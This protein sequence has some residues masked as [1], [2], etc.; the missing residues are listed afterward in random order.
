M[1]RM[2]KGLAVILSLL[3]SLSGAVQVFA[4]TDN[5]IKLRTEEDFLLFAK[6]SYTQMFSEGKKFSLQNDLDLSGMEIEP[7]P[8]FCGTFEGNGHEIRGITIERSG[9]DVGLFRYVE[10]GAVISDLHLSGTITSGADSEHVGGIAGVNRGQISG[11]SFRGMVTGESEVGGIAGYNDETGQ[12]ENCQN[13]GTITGTRRTGGIAGYQEGLIESCVNQGFVNTE[14]ENIVESDESRESQ[15]LDREKLRDNFREEKVQDAGGIAGY[16]EGVIIHCENKASVGYERMGDY[17]G[18]IA[19]RQNGQIQFCE[20]SGNVTGRRYVGGIAGQLEPYLHFLYEPDT[21][22][23][24][25]QKMDELGEIRDTISEILDDTTDQT[26]E[27]LDESDRLMKEIR[28]ITKDYKQEQ[29]EKRD[30]FRE[31]SE[32]HLDAIQ[33]TLD[34]LELDIGSRDARNAMSRISKNAARSKALLNELGNVKPEKGTPSDWEEQELYSQPGQDFW[35]ED[36]DWNQNA[37]AIKEAAA[38]EILYHYGIVREIASCI[39]EILDDIEIVIFNGS[40]DIEDD[41]QDFMDDMDSL[42]CEA[43][44]L[45]S[46]T[47]EYLDNLIDDLDMTDDNLSTR[48]DDIMAEGDDITEILKDGKASLQSEKERLNHLMDQMEQ[49]VRD[50][51]HRVQDQVNRVLDEEDLFDDISDD[52]WHE[53]SNGMIL[54][55]Q[56]SG[57]IMGESESGGIA[58]SVGVKIFEDLKDRIS[59]DGSRSLNVLKETKA[60]ILQCLNEGEIFA[61]YDY[62]GGI[63]GNMNLGLVQSCE[64]YGNVSSEDGEYVGGIAG[65]SRHTIRNSYSMGSAAGEAYVGGIAGLAANLCDNAAMMVVESDSFDRIG[66]IAGASDED[67]LRSGNTYVDEGI[68]AINGIT[69]SGEANGISYEELLKL[70]GLPGRFRKMRVSFLCDGEVIDTVFC[71]YGDPLSSLEFPVLPERDGYYYE[72][73][74]SGQDRII[75]QMKIHA[76]YEPYTSVISSKEEPL[77]V[78]LAEGN[79][80]P[81]TVIDIKPVEGQKGCYYYEIRKEDGTLYEDEAVLRLLTENYPDNAGIKIQTDD[82][83]QR[84]ESRRDGKYL[85]FRGPGSGTVMVTKPFPADKIGLAAAGILLALLALWL[86]KRSE[87]QVKGV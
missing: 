59:T 9:T 61:R 11:C 54:E 46:L 1:R 37:E 71:D 81:G 7:I 10:T 41:I 39:A 73:E 53:V 51:K 19:G 35:I 45:M 30:V 58:G 12:I 83:L 57:R 76:V 60:V 50:G 63:T 85:V 24:L 80:Y 79:F 27:H 55:C 22:D 16:S 84:V 75:N 4:E 86:R 48:M 17:V 70:P 82:G 34:H 25:E 44:E 56:N 3:L 72:W 23:N 28:D 74:T 77:A 42:R 47:R 36:E 18:G 8:L 26:S 43:S 66:A 32:G 68:G 52:A 65:K 29:K 38:E 64:N 87:Q 69:C 78:M 20:N 15:T 49:T 67:G 5:E 33:E 13:Y 31:E 62:A 14:P 6:S 40:A 21:L 2:H